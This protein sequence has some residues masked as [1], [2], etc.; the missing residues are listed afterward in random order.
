M[1]K[2]AMNFIKGWVFLL[3]RWL[4]KVIGVGILRFIVKTDV[5]RSLIIGILVVAIIVL[6]IVTLKII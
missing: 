1:I 3:L 2:L 6:I 5:I 4:E